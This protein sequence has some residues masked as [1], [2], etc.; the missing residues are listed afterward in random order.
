MSL[1][2]LLFACVALAGCGK[3]RACHGLTDK[4]VLESIQRAYANGR[5]T[6]E[7]AR[8]SRLDRERAIAIE[9]FGA[10]GD[11]AF[12]GM[13]FRQ[14]D[15]SILSVRLFEDCSYQTSPGQAA[16]LENWAYPLSKP[17]F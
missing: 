8:N 2:F 3:S 16:D 12:A 9:R 4:E 15:G 6:P 17:S 5:M 7:M 10:K 14:D 11:D 13:I 1:R